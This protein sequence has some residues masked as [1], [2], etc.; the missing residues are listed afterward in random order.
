MTP[1]AGGPWV[2]D[3]VGRRSDADLPVGAARGELKVAA[4]LELDRDVGTF[5]YAPNHA[6]AAGTDRALNTPETE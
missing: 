5:R 1:C 6:E 4:R 2:S 3:R